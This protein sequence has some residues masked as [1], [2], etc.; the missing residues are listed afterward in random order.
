MIGREIVGE[1][2]RNRQRGSTLDHKGRQKRDKNGVI[3]KL[4]NK[5]APKQKKKYPLSS[6]SNNGDSMQGP[7][8]A[9]REGK[10]ATADGMGVASGKTK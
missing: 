6:W 5:R 7:N 1:E 4:N 9:K 3:P 2:G 10:K 8:N